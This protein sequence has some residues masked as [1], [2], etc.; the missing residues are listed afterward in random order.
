MTKTPSWQGKL[1]WGAN[2]FGGQIVSGANCF[3]GLFVSGAFCF[4]GLFVLGGFLTGGLFV[5]WLLSGAF[6][7]GAFV[8]EPRSRSTEGRLNKKWNKS[9]MK[10]SCLEPSS[11]HGSLMEFWRRATQSCF[12][13][14]Y[15]DYFFSTD[16]QISRLFVL[17]STHVQHCTSPIAKTCKKHDKFL[18]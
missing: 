1:V 5:R 9:D 15:N 11:A 16:L 17:I 8:L 13:F 3:W 7:P 6:L 12:S 14:R 10:D 2:Y 4:G 18:T